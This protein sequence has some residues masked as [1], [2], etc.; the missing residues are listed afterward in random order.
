MKKT[1]LVR[2]A[3]VILGIGLFLYG[4]GWFITGSPSYS[5]TINGIPFNFMNITD[6]NFVSLGNN[7]TLNDKAYV[8]EKINEKGL[9]A[10]GFDLSCAMC[11][12]SILEKE[13]IDSI[14]LIVKAAEKDEAS[15][16]IKNGVL[17]VE[18]NEASYLSRNK[19]NTIEIFVPQNTKYVSNFINTNMGDVTI[20]NTSMEDN[21]FQLSMGNIIAKEVVLI[22][23]KI[24]LSMGDLDFEGKIY[25]TTTVDVSMGK[26]KL[27][28]NQK[29]TEL[30]YA[31][32]CSMGKINIDDKKS[33]IESMMGATYNEDNHA[34]NDLIIT[35]SMG[36]IE[37]DYR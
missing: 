37:L 24:E 12:I 23:S 20:K 34:D 6:G 3:S 19:T 8:T 27:N 13:N 16:S 21:D 14:E 5:S 1:S 18:I 2:I 36:D 25:E 4:L 31:L 26:A 29:P 7:V 11:D 15:Y 17:K 28:L 32:D 10:T 33:V 35:N 9:I 30:N 22:N